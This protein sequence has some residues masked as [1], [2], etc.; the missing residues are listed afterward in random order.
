MLVLADTQILIWYVTDPGRLSEEATAVLEGST[1][2]GE[3]LGLSAFSLVELVYASEKKSGAVSSAQARS[4]VAVL[5]DEES[6]FQIIPVDAAIGRRVGHV[7]RV[8]NA[9]PGDRI[10]VATAEMWGLAIVTSDRKIP[11][12]TTT[13]VIW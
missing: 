1:E 3:A 10:V 12:M 5:D 9:D 11:H 13:D 8:V 7:P 6:P 4:I 2:R